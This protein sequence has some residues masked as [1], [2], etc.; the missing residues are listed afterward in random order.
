[1]LF[2]HILLITLKTLILILATHIQLNGAT[3]AIWILIWIK[4]DL[5]F[6]FYFALFC[7]RILWLYQDTE[8]EL[9]QQQMQLMN[10]LD[11]IFSSYCQERQYLW[12]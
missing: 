9:A 4:L 7:G 12:I 8:K 10:E 3:Q 1:M 6:L 2:I 5:W 11:N